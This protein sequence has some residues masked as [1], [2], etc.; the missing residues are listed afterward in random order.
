M[1]HSG[2]KNVLT[3]DKGSTFNTE[4]AVFQLKESTPTIIVDNAKLN[5]KSGL[6][7]QLMA[8]DDPYSGPARPAM[9]G[10]IGV[11]NATF[12]DVKLQG[13]LVN[14]LTAQ[15]GMNLTFENATITGAI[16]TATAVHATGPQGGKL[17]M[18]DATDLY[19]LIGEETE[20]Y[21]PTNGAFG[22][23]VSLKALSKWVVNKTSYLTGLNVADGSGVA[24]PEGYTV[25]MT[26]NGTEKPITVGTYAGKIVLK[27]AA[28]V[29]RT[30]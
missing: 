16:T 18:Q 26:V 13:D 4:K 5:S 19:Y 2:Y 9:T 29:Q 20:T 3:V 24:A 15:A 25:T 23:T 22:A 14:S 7:L 1:A 30:K 12:K 27:V 17:V 8:N 10:P 11:V 28:R 6:I 21:A